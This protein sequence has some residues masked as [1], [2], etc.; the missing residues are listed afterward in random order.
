MNLFVEFYRRIR[1]LLNGETDS[2]RKYIFAVFNEYYSSFYYKSC[3][4]KLLILIISL[5]N[6]VDSPFKPFF[7][8]KPT[9]TGS[10]NFVNNI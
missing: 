3:D 5:L 4:K 6:F 1:S 8:A 9:V 7:L 2:C 10:Y